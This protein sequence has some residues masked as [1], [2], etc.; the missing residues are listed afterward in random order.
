MIDHTA[1]IGFVVRANSVAELFTAAAQA[2]FDLSYDLDAVAEEASARVRISADSAEE[3]MVRW[4][5]EIIFLMET[6]PWVFHRAEVTWG[7]DFSL[8]ARLFGESG[9]PVRHPSCRTVK[10][11][12]YHN[13]S[14]QKKSRGSWEARVLLDV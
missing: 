2:L 8:Q 7:A 14:V 9:N 3:L 12:T 5:N 10:A 1:D 4:L 13:L 6:G 11:A